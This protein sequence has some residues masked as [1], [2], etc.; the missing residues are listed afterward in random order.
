MLPLNGNMTEYSDEL[1]QGLVRV[2]GNEGSACPGCYY[3]DQDELH[4]VVLRQRALSA[5]APISFKSGNGWVTGADFTAAIAIYAR[6][7][8]ISAWAPAAAH[9]HPTY[10]RRSRHAKDI[11]GLQSRRDRRPQL[12]LS[13]ESRHATSC[14]PICRIRS[15]T[16]MN[17]NSSN[18]YPR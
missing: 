13:A 17:E 9:R 4:Y 12:H 15:G 10:S 5:R 8:M 1:T 14:P 11:H 7:I 16:S 2:D 18:C 6:S 3:E